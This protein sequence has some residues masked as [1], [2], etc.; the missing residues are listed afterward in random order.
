M[1]GPK[2]SVADLKMRCQT[3]LDEKR[4]IKIQEELARIEAQRTQMEEEQKKLQIIIKEEQRLKSLLKLEYDKLNELTLNIQ[5]IKS[6]TPNFLSDQFNEI[7]IKINNVKQVYTGDAEQLNAKIISVNSLFNELK[8]KSNNLI[9]EINEK[10]NL[11]K[12]IDIKIDEKQT[13]ENFCLESDN[14]YIKY[15]NELNEIE[16]FSNISKTDLDVLN[17]IKEKIVYLIDNEKDIEEIDKLFYILKGKIF[18]SKKMMNE[19]IQMYDIYQAKINLIKTKKLIPLNDFKNID[20]LQEELAKLDLI[21][22]NNDKLNYISQTIKEVM[23][24]NGVDII[25]NDI[26]D[27]SNSKILK[28]Y[29]EFDSESIISVTQSLEGGVVMEIGLS[30][31]NNESDNGSNL[32]YLQKEKAVAKMIDFCK[33]Y[34]NLVQ[35]LDAKGVVFKNINEMPPDASFAKVINCENI[36]QNKEKQKNNRKNI[37][38]SKGD[39]LNG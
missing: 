33:L 19:I 1:S 10:S 28:G 30:G 24:S 38:I 7:N 15:E 2:F 22:S 32:T 27:E 17:N 20:E 6:T 13:N 37:S 26:L 3:I 29:Y 14:K 8:L 5:K 23:Q 16:L 12:I 39:V 21:L 9:Y 35:Q 18:D 11:D 25:R 34:P 36:N 31:T 4:Q